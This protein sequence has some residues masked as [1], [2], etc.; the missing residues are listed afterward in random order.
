MPCCAGQ[1]PISTLTLTYTA[2]QAKAGSVFRGA[3]PTQSY[4]RVSVGV[5]QGRSPGAGSR[6]T[7]WLHA[8]ASPGSATFLLGSE[9]RVGTAP[10]LPTGVLNLVA[11][12][13]PTVEGQQYS[14]RMA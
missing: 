11:G 14:L 6:A 5:A 1:G 4:L 13:T 7:P 9:E 8:E 10:A 3:P 12:C 2:A